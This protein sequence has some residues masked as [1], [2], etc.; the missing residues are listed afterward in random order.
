MCEHNIICLKRTKYIFC[1]R[2]S[3]VSPE[4]KNMKDSWLVYK[5]Y[6]IVSFICFQTNLQCIL[7]SSSSACRVLL[8]LFRCQKIVNDHNKFK[9]IN[10]FP[11]KVNWKWLRRKWVLCQKP[12]YTCFWRAHFSHSHHYC[13]SK[14]PFANLKM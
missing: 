2:C 6:Y 4:K 14:F 3:R 5:I 12:I 11:E 13:T 7:Q 8:L 1:K 10:L 9:K